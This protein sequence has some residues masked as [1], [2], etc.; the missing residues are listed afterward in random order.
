MVSIQAIPEDE[1][2]FNLISQLK[3]VG[4]Q[5]FPATAAATE[6]VAH[7]VIASVWRNYAMGAPIP[8]TSFKLK[9]PKGGY[10][11]SI[12]VRKVG[13]FNYQIFSDAPVASW[14]EHGTKELDMKK[15]HPY[16]W[17]S[18]VANKGT[19]KSPR[20]V[21][22]LI[23]PF[24]W[25]TNESAGGHFRNVL[26]EQVYAQLQARIRAG[27]FIRT[28]V[29]KGASKLQP[30][31]WGED[32]PRA[33][34]D[35]EE[36]SGG[37]GS[38]LQGVGEDDLEGLVVM[39]GDTENARSSQYF[40]FRVISADSPADSWIRPA[41]PAGNVTQHV[42]RNTQNIVQ[43]AIESSLRKDLGL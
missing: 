38:R 15:T 7:K 26:P 29:L 43:V 20:W 4:E 34:Y 6:Q 28:R 42:V 14:I 39:Q 33:V 23:I 22:Y 10:A 21:P 9:N 17:K 30:N 37:W 40:T 8:G 27:N 25:G 35:N 24:R 19:K 36:E 5:G 12:K 2:L 1:Y 31:V 16:G 13:P 11:R 18:R 32:I 3:K 41:T